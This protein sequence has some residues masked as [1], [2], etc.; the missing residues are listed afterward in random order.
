[1]AHVNQR[2]IWVV[3]LLTLILAV[4][5]RAQLQ[6]GDNASMNLSGNM[7]FGYTGDYSNFAGSAHTLT[8]SGNADFSGFYYSPGFLSFD[9]QP[10]YNES[11]ANSTYQSIFQSGGVSGSASIFSGSHFPGSVAYSKVYNSEGG[12][13]IPGVGNLTTQGNSDNLVVGWGIQIPDYPQVSFQFADGGSDSTVFGTS[14]DAKF[15]SK[16]FGVM[17]SDKWEGFQLN[18]GYHHNVVNSLTPE[19]LAGEG[20]QTS[21]ASS[22][23]VDFSATHRLPWQGAFSVGAG[24]S[25]VTSESSGEKFNATIDMLNSGVGFQPITNLNLGVNAQYTDNLEGSLYQSVISAGGVV[26]PALLNYSTHSLDINSQATYVIP[27]R[28]LTFLASADRRE[29]STIGIPIT[30]NSFDEMVTYGNEFLRGFLTISGGASETAVSGYSSV[31]SRGLFGNATYTRKLQRW[32]LSG[33]FNYSRNNQ[34]AYIGYTSSGYGYSAGIGRKIHTSSYWSFNA[35]QTKS[36]FDNSSGSDNFNQNYSTS[37]SLKH[38][39]MSGSYAKADGTSILT[40]TGLTPITNPTPGLGPFEEIVFNG[41]SYSFGMST[42]P[43]RGLVLSGSYS[44][45]R[46]NTVASSAFSENTTAQLNTMLQYK[47]R[48]LWITAGY[49]KLQ[50]GFSITGQPPTSDSSF[51]VG[52]TRWFK[53]F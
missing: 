7:S 14:S 53:F 1:M 9:V 10:F 25:D 16:T 22:N 29:Q 34:T 47:V 26:P 50:Q 35:S 24:R 39:S 20:P 44:R 37:L 18:G 21:D 15:H 8:P 11:R 49:L 38:F 31:D 2:A 42:T 13:T 23:T 45:A 6:V 41:K 52:I 51:F 30:A 3:S 4:P 36:T 27:E 19:F 46:S 12:L 40:A 28:H 17:A 32:N 48:Q 43:I 33:A 5:A